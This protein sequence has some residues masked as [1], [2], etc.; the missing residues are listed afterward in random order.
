MLAYLR[1]DKK[2]NKGTHIEHD[3]RANRRMLPKQIILRRTRLHDCHGGETHMSR[4]ESYTIR[5]VR[6]LTSELTGDRMVKIPVFF[7]EHSEKQHAHH[8]QPQ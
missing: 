1:E 4:S 5:V 7:F 6:Q 8:R 3:L 2:K